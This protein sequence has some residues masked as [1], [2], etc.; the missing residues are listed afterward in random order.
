MIPLISLGFSNS[1]AQDFESRKVAIEKAHES[2][3]LVKKNFKKALTNA[4]ASKGPEG[5]LGD[6]KIVAPQLS[7][8]N[9]S[10]EIGRTSHKLRNP[11][12]QP[13]EWVKPIL[14]EYVKTPRAQHKSQQIVSLGPNHFGYVEPLYVEAVCLNCHGG[15]LSRGVQKELNSLYP[16]DKATGFKVG[17]FRGLIWLE[18]KTQ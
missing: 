18:S 15:Q 3:G 4:V 14:E 1:F 13:R 9:E 11:V 16:E 7:V 8:K 10:V 6:C 17:D 12:N 5:A 2:V